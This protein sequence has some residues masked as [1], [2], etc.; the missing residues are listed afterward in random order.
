MRGGCHNPARP[1]RFPV[2]G[3]RQARLRQVQAVGVYSHGE[4]GIVRNQEEK[5]AAGGKPRERL[6]MLSAHCRIGMPQDDGRTFGE[7]LRRP[8]GVRDPVLVRHEDQ[9]G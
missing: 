2:R 4:F 5:A 3:L 7:Y 9:R 1:Q 8:D 6:G